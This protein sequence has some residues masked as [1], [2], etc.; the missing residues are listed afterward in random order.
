MTKDSHHHQDDMINKKI[1]E[2]ISECQCTQRKI[3]NITRENG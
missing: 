2:L 1:Q 3:E